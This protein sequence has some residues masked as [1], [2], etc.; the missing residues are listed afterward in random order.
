MPRFHKNLT[1]KGYDLSTITGHQEF[2]RFADFEMKFPYDITPIDITHIVR[3][4]VMKSS[5]E[6]LFYFRI[7]ELFSTAV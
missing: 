1:N 7:V 3:E 2:F 5:G 6:S 4:F